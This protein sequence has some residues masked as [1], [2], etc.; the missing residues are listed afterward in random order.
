M[1]SRVCVCLLVSALMVSAS[2]WAQDPVSQTGKGT[3]TGHVICGDTQRPA[4]FATVALFGVPAKVTA[5]PLP[6]PNA[7]D[8][9]KTK[10]MMAAFAAI[11]N[12]NMV[13]VETGLDGS[14]TATDVA[15]GDYYVFGA[16]AGYVS[17]LNEVT[18]LAD[19]GADLKQPLPGVPIVHVSADRETSVD[20]TMQ[21][22]AA[23]S[24]TISWDDG[25]PVAGAVFVATPAKRDAK[26]P[27]QFSMLAMAGMTN[28]LSAIS[29]DLGHY[30][31]TGLVPGD[32]ILKASLKTG[33]QMGLGSS[34]MNLMKMAAVTPLVV[35]APAGFHK[36]DAKPI[37]LQAGQDMSGE[38]VTLNLTDVHSV[39]G[40]VVST[41]DHHGINQATVKLTDANDKEFVRSAAVDDAGNFTV[42]FVPQGTY[43]MTVTD[44]ADTAP[45]DSKKKGGLFNF[46]NDKTVRSYVDGSQSVIVADSDVTGQVVSLAVDKNTKQ[47]PDVGKVIGAMFGGSDSSTK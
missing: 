31:V 26:P 42:T 14:F 21:R 19:G 37:T 9:A 41:E 17:P 10:T 38:D 28:G 7:S 3:V 4:R 1:K 13:T 39:S 25:S 32:Y 23:I 34:S 22:G 43:T 27:L 24:G 29:D 33:T 5:A 30:R 20:V 35:Y 46:G 47:T 12:T 18:A 2:V 45:S 36:T 6:N 16:A 40:S 15:P 11:G 44:A 8:A